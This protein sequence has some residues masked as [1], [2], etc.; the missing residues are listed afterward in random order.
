MKYLVLSEYFFSPL[1]KCLFSAAVKWRLH[2]VETPSAGKRLNN[3]VTFLKL[4][5]VNILVIERKKIDLVKEKM[6]EW[7]FQ[8]EQK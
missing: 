7:H 3:S 2:K 6:F 8:M 4:V 5:A 1:V